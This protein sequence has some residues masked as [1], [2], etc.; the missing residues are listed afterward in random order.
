MFSQGNN[1][2]IVL[3]FLEV[4]LE[5]LIKDRVVFSPADIKSWMK[6]LMAGLAHLHRN[7][8]LHRVI[9]PPLLPGALLLRMVVIGY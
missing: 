8:I 2:N 4:D 5:M 3:E 9:S 6:M 1:I 7:W